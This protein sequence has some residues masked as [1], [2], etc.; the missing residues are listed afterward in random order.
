M[1]E[2]YQSKNKTPKQQFLEQMEE[3]YQ[4]NILVSKQFNNNRYC[5]TGNNRVVSRQRK[6]WQNISIIL[7]SHD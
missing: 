2:N 3:N 6:F 5:S 1:E 7:S 4:K